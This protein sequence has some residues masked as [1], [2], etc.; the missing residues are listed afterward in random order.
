M[1]AWLL[2]DLSSN[3]SSAASFGLECAAP[4]VTPLAS[5]LSSA[6]EARQSV[7]TKVPGSQLYVCKI[8]A[9][10]LKGK[11]LRAVNC[12][13]TYRLMRT[14]SSANGMSTQAFAVSLSCSWQF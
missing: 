14:N 6:T 2:R 5:V 4:C 10:S 13:Q 11:I 8:L 1:L 7:W 3:S 9:F 12:T